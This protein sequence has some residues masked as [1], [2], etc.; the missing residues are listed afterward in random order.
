MASGD[1]H[2]V[3]AKLL[4][5]HLEFL[6][7]NWPESIRLHAIA[8]LAIFVKQV[9]FRFG[10]IEFFQFGNFLFEGGPLDALSVLI[11]HVLLQMASRLPSIQ[12]AGAALLQ[13]ILRSGYET[14]QTQLGM[15]CIIHLQC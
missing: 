9:T 1:H 6:K 10:C 14:V 4:S 2:E 8:A 12:S 3:F 5:I 7:E 15:F 11:E 13:L